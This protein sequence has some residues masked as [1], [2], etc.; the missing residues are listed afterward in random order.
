MEVTDE[1][2][3]VDRSSEESALSS[4]KTRSMFVTLET[5][6]PETFSFVRDVQFWKAWFMLVRLR[7]SQAERSSV[8]REVQSE[9]MQLIVWHFD[10]SSLETSAVFMFRSSA[11]QCPVPIGEMP[12]S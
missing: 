7:V 4:E 10:M 6:H 12:S 3:Q 5:S 9:N 1:L 8:S 11:N 2:S